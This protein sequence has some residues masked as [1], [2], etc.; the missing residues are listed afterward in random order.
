MFVT[1]ETFQ[2]ETSSEASLWHWRNMS[3]MSVTFETFQLET[4]SESR[5]EQ[6]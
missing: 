1:F 6:P 5:L 3:P 4:S 2:L